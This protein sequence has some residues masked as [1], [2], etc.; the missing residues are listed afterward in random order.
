VFGVARVFDGKTR[1]SSFH[2]P[3]QDEIKTDL[4]GQKGD[5]P[6]SDWAEC[7]RWKYSFTGLS[8]QPRNETESET[9]FPVVME[10][11][12]GEPFLLERRL[13]DIPGNETDA[14]RAVVVAVKTKN[15][16]SDLCFA[17]GRPDKLRKFDNRKAKFEI[18]GESG[19]YSTDE[20][21]LRQATLM[22]GT[23]LSTPRVILQASARE[24]AGVGDSARQ[25]TFVSLRRVE[26]GVFQL[27]GDVDLSVS[28]K[29]NVIEIS[30]DRTTWAPLNG[31]KD[32]P[33]YHAK[34][35]AAKIL[36]G[37]VF[38]RAVK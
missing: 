15:E 37:P 19:F 8:F 18:A 3:I 11:Y 12:V 4:L 29:G 31:K 36:E 33:W 28:L 22:G 30:K 9:V 20:N 21:G 16:H 26:S 35:G 17:D 25:N 14:Q 23:M 34:L 10:P 6:L 7:S 5:R 13:I 1:T 24:R 2:G 27:E 38:L 32:G